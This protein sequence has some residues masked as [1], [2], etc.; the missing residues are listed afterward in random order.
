MEARSL[1]LGQAA[2]KRKSK[3]LNPGSQNLLLNSVL[4]CLAIGKGGIVMV[5]AGML[6]KEKQR[7]SGI[8]VPYSLSSLR[9]WLCS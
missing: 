3:D 8:S 6:R 5:D 1:I 2:S 7:I 4:Y 9:A